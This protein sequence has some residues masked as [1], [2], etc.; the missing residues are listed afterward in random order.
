[1]IK[2]CKD[3]RLA[4]LPWIYPLWGPLAL[5][6]N[7]RLYGHGMPGAPYRREFWSSRLWKRT[8]WGR[9]EFGRRA[10]RLQELSRRYQKPPP[11]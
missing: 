6:L 10:M 3:C 11:R 1:M 9:R 2:L 7:T 4:F 8:P 5:W